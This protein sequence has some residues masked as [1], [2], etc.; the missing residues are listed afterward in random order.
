[1]QDSNFS[2]VNTDRRIY[3]ISSIDVTMCHKKG[4]VAKSSCPLLCQRSHDSILYKQYKSNRLLASKGFGTHSLPCPG[5]FWL[6]T[7]VVSGL[8]QFRFCS[9]SAA[10]MTTCTFRAFGLICGN[11]KTLLTH[12]GQNIM[13][14]IYSGSKTFSADCTITWHSGRKIAGA[15][16]RT[17]RR[18]MLLQI[19]MSHLESVKNTCYPWLCAMK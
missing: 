7:Y 3:V 10:F 18:H 17:F 12:T 4:K 19:S 8:R 14:I 11:L 9:E 1:M 6:V 13:K 5:L 16:G 15:Q 2:Q